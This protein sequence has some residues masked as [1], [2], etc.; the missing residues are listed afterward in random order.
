MKK[1]E[2]NSCKL[3]I[4]RRRNI[5]FLHFNLKETVAKKGARGREILSLC[6]L[7]EKKQLQIRELEKEKY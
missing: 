4:Q 7:T 3:G 1:L 6:I 2:R 5:N